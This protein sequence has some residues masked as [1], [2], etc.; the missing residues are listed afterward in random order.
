MQRTVILSGLGV[1]VAL[2]ALWAT[3][4]FASLTTW[5]LAEQRWVQDA[6]AQGIR[7]VRAG[8][9]GAL[10]ALLGVCFAYGFLHAVGPGHGKVLIGAYGVARRVRMAP[11]MAVALVASI[12]QAA[13]AVLLVAALFAALGWTRAR[14]V[15]VSEGVMA[16]LGHFMIAGL[17]LWLVWRGVRGLR[18]QGAAHAHDHIH[19]AHCGH[20]HGPSAADVAALTGW[21]DTAAL[22]AGIAMRPCTGALFLLILT[23]GMGIAWVG[24]AGAFVMGLGTASVTVAVALLAVWSREGALATLSQG[25][26]ARALPMVEIMAGALVVIVTLQML[27][28]GL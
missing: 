21:R 26:M 23:F 28:A 27:R 12:A 24:V 5:A 8:Q 22:V 16:P 3:G 9:A 11:L 15:G 18:A 7:A 6:M 17:G 2:G 10:M 14:V 13:V 4:A 20:A 1:A 25:R 19:D